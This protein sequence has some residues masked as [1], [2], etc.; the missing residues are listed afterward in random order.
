V[1]PY[2]SRES[3]YAV[4]TVIDPADA[5]AT[6]RVSLFDHDIAGKDVLSLSTIEHIGAKQYDLKEDKTPVQAFEYIATKSRRFLISIPYGWV[7][8]VVL[9]KKLLA[10][11]GLLAEAGINVYTVTRQADETWQASDD[12]KPY[13]TR[14][15]PWANTVIIAERGGLL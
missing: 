14:E 7:N 11:R 9:E 6:Q 15:K 8:S 12:L 5:K 1:T 2:Y 3:G 13:G 10:E 4:G